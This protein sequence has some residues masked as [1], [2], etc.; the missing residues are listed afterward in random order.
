MI[1][2]PIHGIGATPAGGIPVSTVDKSNTY[3][4]A[5]MGNE[6]FGLNRMIILDPAGEA[7]ES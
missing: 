1:T 4:M 3:Q 2:A 6:F 7:S 5:H